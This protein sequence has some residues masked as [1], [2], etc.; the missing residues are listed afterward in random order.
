MIFFVVRQ[1]QAENSAV[2]VCVQRIFKSNFLPSDSAKVK[3]NLCLWQMTF[4]F[5]S[6]N[7]QKAN[8]GFNCYAHSYRNEIYMHTLYTNC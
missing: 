8:D 3:Y 7:C 5:D 1:Q 4:I 6:V 2:S